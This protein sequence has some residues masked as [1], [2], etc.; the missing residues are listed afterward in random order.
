MRPQTQHLLLITNITYQ[1]CI[2]GSLQLS[3]ACQPLLLE[4]RSMALSELH[5][6]PPT[7][8]TESITAMAILPAA[9]LAIATQESAVEDPAQ[10]KS[11]HDPNRTLFF[12]LPLELRFMIYEFILIASKPIM[13]LG[14]YIPKKN[15]S[16]WPPRPHFCNIKAPYPSPRCNIMALCLANRQTYAE[17]APIF[18][19]NNDI[20]FQQCTLRIPRAFQ[21]KLFVTHLQHVSIGIHRF[22]SSDEF[23]NGVDAAIAFRITEV[24]RVCPR[25]RTW[26]IY[27]PVLRAEPPRSWRR[28]WAKEISKLRRSL[29][30][31]IMAPIPLI[32]FL[33]ATIVILDA[34]FRPYRSRE[35]C[36]GEL[37][38]FAMFDCIY[39]IVRPYLTKYGR[40]RA[41]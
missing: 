29:D 12:T 6:C 15:S 27:I 16:L 11:E 22:T 32:I 13:W 39:F 35:Q 26:T 31:M 9:S 4:N 25:L 34:T 14:D 21:S 7:R 36:L 1:G 37:I 10:S 33:Q 41:P 2:R 3:L 19:R 40:Y 8:T 18:Y 28:F 17:S 24:A 23:L 38:G 5:Q 20:L 30:S